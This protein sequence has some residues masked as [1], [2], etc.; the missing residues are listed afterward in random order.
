MTR[1]ASNIPCYTF[2][3]DLAWRSRRYGAHAAAS[4]WD[5]NA[6]VD[7]VTIA[8]LH[9]WCVWRQGRQPA[10]QCGAAGHAHRGA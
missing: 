1:T 3:T 10:S 6:D 5:P 4:E 7:T 9:A 2:G 8:D